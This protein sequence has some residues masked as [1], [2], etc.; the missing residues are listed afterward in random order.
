MTHSRNPE[1]KTKRER[2]T[3]GWVFLSASP[4]SRELLFQSGAE[5]ARAQQKKPNPKSEIRNK[6]KSPKKKIPNGKK[7][8]FGFW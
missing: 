4:N 3:G 8:G 2:P 1:Q 7:S 6:S 5:V